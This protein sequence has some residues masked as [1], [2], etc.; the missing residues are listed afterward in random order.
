MRTFLVPRTDYSIEDTW[1]VFG[2]KATG[3]DDIV[4][5]NAFV[6]EYRT[7][8]ASDG[9]LCANPGQ[10]ENDAPL[11]RL[12]W[13]QI[14]V[15]SVSSAALGAAR[16]AVSAFLE[17]AKARVS[18]NTG[19]ATKADPLALAAAARAYAQVDEM[20]AVLHRNFDRLLA[21]ADRKE[22]MP[23]DERLLYR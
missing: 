7:H 3:S 20:E 8:K 17:I 14:F 2:L 1:H 11:Y 6:P 16:G 10:Q 21:Y 4:V 13:A 9:F 12:P 5:D 15:R 19:K 18:T 23:V 22:P